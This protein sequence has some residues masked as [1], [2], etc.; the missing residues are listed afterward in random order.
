MFSYKF[1]M[2]ARVHFLYSQKD[3][4]LEFLKGIAFSVIFSLDYDVDIKNKQ[5]LTK[6]AINYVNKK[7][8]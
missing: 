5:Y 8:L 1:Y 4:S 7:D 3:V 6:E 2:R